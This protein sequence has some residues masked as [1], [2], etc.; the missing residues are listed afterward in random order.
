MKLKACRL[1]RKIAVF[2]HVSRL[3]LE[4]VQQRL[5]VNAMNPSRQNRVEV[6]H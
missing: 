3:G 5:V 6:I 1:E 2:E 4:I